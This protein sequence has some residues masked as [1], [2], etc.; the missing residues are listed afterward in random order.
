VPGE[1][2]RLVAEAR[3]MAAVTGRRPH[4]PPGATETQ[5]AG[6]AP[7]MDND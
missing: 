6:E 5:L 4:P 7:R 3:V 1:L 2:A